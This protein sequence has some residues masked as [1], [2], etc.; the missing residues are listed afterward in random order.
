MIS[1]KRGDTMSEPLIIIS[2]FRVKEG[3]LDDLKRYYSKNTE[4]FKANEPQIIA[5]HAFLNQDGTEVTNI[6]FHP[7]TD[8]MDFHMKLLTDNWDEYFSE[9][10]QLFEILKVEYYGTPPQSALEMDLQR[11]WDLRLKP[12]H[13]AGFTRSAAS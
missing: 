2:T 6:Q 12:I 9:Y 7:D 11:E 4:F 13:I 10:G 5:F 3:K 1:I 8:S